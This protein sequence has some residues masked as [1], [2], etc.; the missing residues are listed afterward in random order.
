MHIAATIAN[1][2]RAAGAA[3]GAGKLYSRSPSDENDI[4][5]APTQLRPTRTHERIEIEI[6]IDFPVRGAL[7][8]SL[9]Q[10]SYNV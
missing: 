10:T 3:A 5:H 9:P 2:T 7:K 1:P 8:Y 6:E 4:P